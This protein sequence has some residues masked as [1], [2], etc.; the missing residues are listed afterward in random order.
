MPL[1]FNLK[2]LHV[3]YFTH[4]RSPCCISPRK[5]AK[6]ALIISSIFYTSVYDSNFK[7]FDLNLWSLRE[8]TCTCCKV[9]DYGS[10]VVVDSVPC[11]NTAFYAYKRYA[12][13][14][15]F[16]VYCCCNPLVCINQMGHSWCKQRFFIV[17]VN[18]FVFRDGRE[19]KVLWSLLCFQVVLVSVS[20]TT[21]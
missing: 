10:S 15:H 2:W 7:T 13:I 17:R 18:F 12:V 3:T 14:E 5:E 21:L 8:R 11:A 9:G 6:F 4:I 1:H 16:L 20:Y 19:G